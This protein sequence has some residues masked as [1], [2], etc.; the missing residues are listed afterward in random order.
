MPSRVD[1][2]AALQVGA[3]QLSQRDLLGVRDQQRRTNPSATTTSRMPSTRDGSRP[4]RALMAP[5]SWGLANC[6]SS[7]ASRAAV[8]VPNAHTE[9]LSSSMTRPAC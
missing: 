2:L 7:P 8:R 9:L 6:S 5:S 1:E 3:A 4:E